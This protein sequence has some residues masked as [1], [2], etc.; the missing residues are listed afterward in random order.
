[1]VTKKTV[2]MLNLHEEQIEHKH[3]FLCDHRWYKFSLR[4]SGYWSVTSPIGTRYTYRST[5]TQPMVMPGI[6][7]EA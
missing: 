2:F 7:V 4:V 6:L 3:C 1:M 5:R